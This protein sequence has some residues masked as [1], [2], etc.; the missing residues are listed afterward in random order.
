MGLNNATNATPEL[1]D[2]ANDAR[3]E[4]ETTTPQAPHN[5]SGEDFHAFFRMKPLEF[6]GGLDPVADHDW[7]VSMERVL[8]VV[9]CSE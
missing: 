4:R 9:R 6:L 2:D 5:F 8:Q 7:S 1:D 3:H